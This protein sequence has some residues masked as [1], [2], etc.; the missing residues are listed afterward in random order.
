MAFVRINQS[1][2][3]PALAVCTGGRNIAEVSVHRSWR[4]ARFHRTLR[5][6][7]RGRE[8]DGDPFPYGTLIVNITACVIIGFT[9]T[10]LGRHSDIGPA[11][12]FLVPVGFIGRTAR[13]RPTNGRH[14]STFERALSELLP[15]MRRKLWPGSVQ[16]WRGRSSVIC[17]VERRHLAN[18]CWGHDPRCAQCRS[19]AAGTTRT[20]IVL[21]K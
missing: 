1:R 13:S 6:R 9:M 20:V 14:W 4:S 8:S 17:S 21:L 7:F 15:C 10:Y 11:L 16:V 2:H 18:P 12:R 19:G 5:G 3:S